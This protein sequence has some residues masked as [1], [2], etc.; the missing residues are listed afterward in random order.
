[1][2]TTD[3]K[4]YIHETV[5]STVNSAIINAHS[6]LIEKVLIPYFDQLHQDNRNLED[7]LQER[8]DLIGE[9]LKDHEK[10]ITKLEVKTGL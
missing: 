1:M 5:T 2:L 10:R 7:K 6:E 8:I 3:D 9:H 4:K